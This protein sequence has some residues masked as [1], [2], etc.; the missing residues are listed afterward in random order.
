MDGWIDGLQSVERS[1]Q[2]FFSRRHATKLSPWAFRIGVL[3]E[4]WLTNITIRDKRVFNGNGE[5]KKTA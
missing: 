4:P 5:N 1:I 3:L 2:V